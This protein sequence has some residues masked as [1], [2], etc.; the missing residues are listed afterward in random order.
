MVPA[1]VLS[2]AVA[3]LTN[4]GTQSLYLCD[5]IFSRQLFEVVV[6][7][8]SVSCL[9]VAVLLSKVAS[10]VEEIRYRWREQVVVIFLTFLLKREH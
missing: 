4:S 1:Q 10:S 5:Q 3:V 8:V 7:H 9:A 6:V 2:T